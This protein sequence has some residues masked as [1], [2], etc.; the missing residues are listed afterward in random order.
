[1]NDCGTKIFFVIY[2]IPAVRAEI[3][4]NVIAF[5][6]S[7]FR[8]ALMAVHM[9]ETEDIQAAQS[10]PIPVRAPEGRALAMMSAARRRKNSLGI[11]CFNFIDFECHSISGIV[12]SPC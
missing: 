11:P 7:T 6:G 9:V 8:G 3:G 2:E 10:K 1:M 4:F 12:A 5:E